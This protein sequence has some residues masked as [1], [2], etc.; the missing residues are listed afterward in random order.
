MIWNISSLQV[1]VNPKM[2][3]LGLVDH[4]GG[5]FTIGDTEKD[6]PQITFKESLSSS[7]VKCGANVLKFTRPVFSS[8]PHCAVLE[9]G[10]SNLK[11]E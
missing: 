9:D 2:M 5:R 10:A 7:V 6:H 4:N 3:S 8:L 1:N 11:G